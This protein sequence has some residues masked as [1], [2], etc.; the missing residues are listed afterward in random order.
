MIFTAPSQWVQHN[1]LPLVYF[2]PM[3]L[4]PRYSPRLVGVLLS[5]FL[6]LSPALLRGAEQILTLDDST[7]IKLFIFSPENHGSGPWPLGVLVPGGQGQESSA[8]AQSWFGRELAN[9]GW[10]VAMPVSS[11]KD[12]FVGK[13]GERIPKIVDALQSNYR[14]V[15]GRTLLVGVSTGGSSALEIATQNPQDYLGVVA[16]P[17]RLPENE[18][19]PPLQGLPVFLRIAEEDYFRWDRLLPDMAARLEAAGAAVNAAL[20]PGARHTFGIDWEALEAWLGGLR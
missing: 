14:V 17:G 1:G 7:T 9:R 2:R 11:D 3:N 4:Q 10:L 16:V 8:R 19:L 18:T 13:H 15:P 12:A 6:G 20:V 5:L